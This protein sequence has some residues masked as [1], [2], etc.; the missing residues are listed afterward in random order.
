M[1]KLMK[2]VPKFLGKQMKKHNQIVV[3]FGMEQLAE[4]HFTSF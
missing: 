4:F 1:A 2:K 3:Q